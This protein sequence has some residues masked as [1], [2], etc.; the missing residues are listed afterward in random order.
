MTALDLPAIRAL[1]EGATPGPWR[2]R[3]CSPCTERGRLEVNIWDEAGN[4]LITNWCD[5][6]GYHAPDAAFIAAA[7]SIVAQLVAAVERAEKVH[8]PI[9]ALMYSGSHQRLVKVCTGCGTDDGNWQR[10]PCPTIKAIREGG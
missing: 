4:I 2:V 1:L 8:E 6:D 10:W 3:E 7:P 5:D 9:E